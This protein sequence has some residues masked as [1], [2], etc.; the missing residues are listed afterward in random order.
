MASWKPA[1]L[2]LALTKRNAATNKF[3]VDIDS[4]GNARFDDTEAHRM[5]S[6][7]IEHRGKWFL[8]PTGRRG[9]ELYLV[10]VLKRSTP[11]QAAAVV[12]AG[13][14]KAVDEGHVTDVTVAARV[15]TPGRLNIALG[16]KTRAGH[17][18]SLAL[19]V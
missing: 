3:D 5:A 6:L 1:G 18:G 4:T 9:S 17:S 11:S 14:Q 2:D 19:K 7:A 15:P 8:D 13:V 12:S 16:W 10:K